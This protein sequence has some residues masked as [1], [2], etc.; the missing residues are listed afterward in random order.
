MNEVGITTF[1]VDKK[2]A[3]L[4]QT[5]NPNLRFSNF[6]R[7][8]LNMELNLWHSDSEVHFLFIIPPCLLLNNLVLVYNPLWHHPSTNTYI[9]V[10]ANRSSLGSC[11]LT[12]R[13]PLLSRKPADQ[14]SP[15]Y[16][17]SST[18]KPLD[19]PCFQTK[20]P[21]LLHQTL[22]YKILLKIH[23][24]EAFSDDLHPLPITPKKHPWKSSCVKGPMPGKQEAKGTEDKE[25]RKEHP[26]ILRLYQMQHPPLS[27]QLIKPN[28]ETPPILFL[29]SPAKTVSPNLKITTSQK[30]RSFYHLPLTLSQ[31][32]QKSQWCYL[33]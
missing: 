5:R 25:L 6:P 27:G 1:I 4:L 3:E 29:P 30:A 19:K 13:F 10:L 11:Y 33:S 32:A 22:S 9:K 14:F 12:I 15:H 20:M 2:T 8:K 31:G 18:F 16:S 24:H 21:F 26:R 28:W 17:L 7:V 23:L